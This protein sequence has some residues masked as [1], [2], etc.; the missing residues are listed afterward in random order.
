MLNLSKINKLSRGNFPKFI[1]EPFCLFI[2][3]LKKTIS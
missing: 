3:L 2:Y 1:G